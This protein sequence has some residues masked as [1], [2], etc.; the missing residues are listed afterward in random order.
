MDIYLSSIGMLKDAF[1][2]GEIPAEECMILCSFYGITDFEK[3]YLNRFKKIM[4]DSGAFSFIHGKGREIL[5]WDKYLDDYAQFINEYDI[6]LFFELDIDNLVGLPKVEEFRE[7]LRKKTGKLPIPVWHPNRGIKDFI[8]ICQEY[9][10]V[11]VGSAKVHGISRQVHE[12]TLPWF[13]ETAHK[14]GA[15]IHGLGYT[16]LDGLLHYKFDS[17]DSTTWLVG[18]RYGNV[19]RINEAGG[20]ISGKRGTQ[21]LSFQSHVPEGLRVSSTFEL[22]KVNF[23]T[24]LN[25]QKYAEKNL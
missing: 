5:N 13:I 9:P 16:A 3:E 19:V 15:K 10:Y 17:V 14:Y 1:R 2:S 25:F 6:Q 22:S 8:K 24:F 12:K 11:A 4:I 7:T 23:M 18:A 20:K 21:F